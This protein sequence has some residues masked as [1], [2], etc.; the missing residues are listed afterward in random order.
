[1][2]KNEFVYRNGKNKNI[3][4]NVTNSFSWFRHKGG[5]HE[6]Q[7]TWEATYVYTCRFYENGLRRLPDL[8]INNIIITARATIQ[9][10]QGVDVC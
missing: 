9:S 6:K 2:R 5:G 3:S 1:M 4:L 8:K 7:S 10:D